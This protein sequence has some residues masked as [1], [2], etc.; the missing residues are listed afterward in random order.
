[1]SIIVWVRMLFSVV[2][3]WLFWEFGGGVA[4][5]LSALVI[6]QGEVLALAIK[7]QNQRQDRMEAVIHTWFESVTEH[8]KKRDTYRRT[9]LH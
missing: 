7:L 4:A 5:V 6:A 1:M 2:A 9:G 3:V 8:L